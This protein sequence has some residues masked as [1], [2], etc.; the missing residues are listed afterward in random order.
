MATPA[1]FLAASVMKTGSRPCSCRFRFV[2]HACFIDSD[3]HVLQPPHLGVKPNG[4][5]LLLPPAEG[6]SRAALFE[7]APPAGGA[8][9]RPHLKRQIN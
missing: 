4:W 8:T 3:R 6:C 1:F 2:R 5:I 9:E 7:E